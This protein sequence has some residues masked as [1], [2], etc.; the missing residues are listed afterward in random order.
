M[1][2]CLNSLSILKPI[3]PAYPHNFGIPSVVLHSAHE[4]QGMADVMSPWSD[5]VAED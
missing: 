3:G 5:A 4:N 2:P 1:R